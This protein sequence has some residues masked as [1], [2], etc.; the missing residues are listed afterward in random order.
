MSPDIYQF[1]DFRAFLKACFEAKVAASLEAG[2][3]R[4][5]QRQFARDAGFANPGYFNDVLKGFK[6]LS[7]NAAEKM[8]GVF[9][10][11]PHETDFLKLLADYGQA[12]SPEKKDALYRHI[13]AR[14]NRSRFT[15]L[16]PAL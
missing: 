16:N 13:L 14:R 6:P 11:K 15:R 12:R 10:L 3:R 9:G 4:Y 1:D 5:S 8:A 7:A 2:G